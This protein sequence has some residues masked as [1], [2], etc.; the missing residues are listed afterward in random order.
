MFWSFPLRILGISNFP[1]IHNDVHVNVRS[2]V[3]QREP[4]RTIQHKHNSIS[5][6]QLRRQMI[7]TEDGKRKRVSKACNACRSRKLKCDAGQPVCS[8]CASNGSPC[9]YTHTPKKRTTN[10]V[11]KQPVTTSNPSNIS[12]LNERMSRMESLITTLV[13]RLDPTL[14]RK[15]PAS[16]E[17]EAEHGDIDDD[18]DSDDDDNS[19]LRA[20]SKSPT[21]GQTTDD[22][23]TT[24]HGDPSKVGVH[25]KYFG[26]QSTFSILSA[27][28]IEW[29]GK[30]VGDPYLLKNFQEFHRKMAAIF[31]W[32]NRQWIEPIHKSEL[33]AFPDR[34]FSLQLCSLFYDNFCFATLILKKEELVSLFETHFASQDRKHRSKRLTNSDYLTMTV[35]IAMGSQFMM[36]GLQ[37]SGSKEDN[38]YLGEI[39]D[40]MTDNAIFY[41]SRV[42]VISEGLRTVQALIIFDLFTQFTTSSPQN[43]ILV[44]TM[45]RYAQELGLHRR[46][47]LVGL[48]PEEVAH[49]RRIWLLVYIFDRGCCMMSGKPPIINTD[50]VSSVY[51]H[52]MIDVLLYN[53]PDEV[54]KLVHDVDFDLVSLIERLE[55]TP[56]DP[57]AYMKEPLQLI[58]PY[59]FGLLSSLTSKAYTKLFSAHA[60]RGKSLNE[61]L[62]IIDELNAEIEGVV[63]K[64][65]TCMRPGVD[66]RNIK[67]IRLKYDTAA[68]HFQYYQLRM[69]INRMAFARSW[70]NSH[71]PASEPHASQ[72]PHQIRLIN[73]CLEAAR[74][75][76]RL[77]ESVGPYKHNL[78]A[79]YASFQF[80]SAFFT[81]FTGFLEFPS[82]PHFKTDIDLA[83]K[84]SQR[85]AEAM[86]M[87]NG[88]TN[89]V[90]VYN[91]ICVSVRFFLRAAVLGYNHANQDKLDLTELDAGIAHY[92]KILGEM[93]DECNQKLRAN[94]PLC[95]VPR[96]VPSKLN[97]AGSSRPMSR[98]ESRSDSHSPNS[99]SFQ[100]ERPLMQQMNK[101]YSN[102]MFNMHQ[103]STQPPLLPLPNQTEQL[104]NPDMGDGPMGSPLNDS[105]ISGLTD[106]QIASF[107][108]FEN[109]R[110]AN[111]LQHVFSL[112]NFY[113][114]ENEATFDVDPNLMF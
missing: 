89:D 67:S 102:G 76:I 3:C 66:I 26:S 54:R 15:T 87:S 48:S 44:S 37:E 108:M 63:Q 74:T 103:R 94:D 40:R 98:S 99:T 21:M 72:S 96:T 106:D 110:N 55:S 68:L 31:L 18:D 7:E 5:S 70:L 46:E 24:A 95:A 64:V 38:A 1:K 14:S 8:R 90:Y 101:S 79:H 39:R 59:Y 85:L 93:S 69:T 41:Y 9:E 47:S 71:E 20:I 86:S 78:F 80:F 29:L 91:I 50:D 11:K 22:D 23:P 45:V 112:P 61:V 65:P 60:L 28:G 100:L 113:M 83:F 53:A 81:L 30:R 52:E 73:N 77:L 51:V 36:D 111:I 88:R 84:V 12:D 16:T 35:C 82:S 114:N 92:D 34:E 75:I 57:L 4:H 27:K 33:T 10:Q 104:F 13:G 19:R 109:Q 42:S 62:D 32:T 97:L 6:F 25:H 43:Y 58:T 56:D 105:Q 107:E 49:R 2:T 17:D